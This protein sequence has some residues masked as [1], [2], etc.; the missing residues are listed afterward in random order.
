ML[1]KPNLRLDDTSDDE[2]LLDESMAADDY[3]IFNSLAQTVIKQPLKTPNSKVQK[4]IPPEE[5]IGKP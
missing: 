1:K 5:P 2:N 3:G 4:L